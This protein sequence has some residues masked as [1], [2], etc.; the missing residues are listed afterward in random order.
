[1]KRLI[2]ILCISTLFT[3]CELLYS[4][5][6]IEVSP[7]TELSF[8]CNADSVTLIVS[9]NGNWTAGELP[10][11]ISVSPAEGNG[12]DQITVSV[13]ENSTE[14]NREGSF[15]LVCGNASAIVVVTQYGI[16]DSNYADLGLEEPGTSMTYDKNSGTLTVTYTDSTP[17]VVEQGNAVVLGAKYQYDIRVVQS[18]SVSGKTLT[19]R[20]SEGNMCDLFK[21]TSFTLITSGFANT[22]SIGERVIFPS[23]VGYFD[24]HGT[25]HKTHD[26]KGE[27]FQNGQELLAFHTDFNGRTIAQGS[28]GRLYWETCSFDAS[29]NGEFRFDFGEK[30][31]DE[32]RSKGDIKAFS[33]ALMG[34]IDMDFLLHYTYSAGYSEDDDEIIQKNIIRTLSFKFLV[35]NVPV[36][37][38]VDTHLGKCTE[39][40]AE[41]QID[42]T[43]GVKLGTD[44][45]MG[46]EWT[47]ESGARAIPEV[48]PYLELHH[49][50]FEA[51][52]SA[53][54]KVSYY[55]HIDI[56]LYKFLGPWVEPR[57]YLKETVEAGLRASTGGEEYIGYKAETFAGLDM[58][59]G[60]DLDFGI[61]EFN[62]WES[63]MF[64]PVKDQLLFEA[65]SRITLVSP[66]N[67]T[68]VKSGESVTAEFL[69]ESYS[70]L[71][72]IY[73]PCPLALVNLEVDGGILENKFAI[74]DCDGNTHAVWNPSGERS[75]SET[76]IRTMTA[77]VIAADGTLIDD[78]SIMIKVGQPYVNAMIT[79]IEMDGI[80]LAGSSSRIDFTATAR[81][82]TDK[83]IEDHK[84]LIDTSI[85]GSIIYDYYDST[86][87][88]Q[89]IIYD[90][91]LPLSLED[92]SF[93]DD[94]AS[95]K[96]NI[97]LTLHSDS[98]KEIT[99]EPYRFEI[100]ETFELDLSFPEYA[101]YYPAN[102]G[103]IRRAYLDLGY[104]EWV[105]SI[106]IVS[107]GCEP[108]GG[109]SV[110]VLPPDDSHHDC[111][112][113]LLCIYELL[114]TTL[115]YDEFVN[116]YYIEYYS[117]TP[118]SCLKLCRHKFKLKFTF[119]NGDSIYSK[120][121]WLFSG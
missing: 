95:I 84:L 74:S 68:T 6:F 10:Q 53:D 111:D 79:G 32:I 77:K 121:K 109:Y 82:Y 33:Y 93:R 55:P 113:N 63:D 52:A 118:T 56:R 46:V 12:G 64:N 15:T 85:L 81:I 117:P 25:Y 2:I 61:C 114:N 5:D 97:Y 16:L 29:L 83:K 60:L 19:L 72:S 13:T 103:Y 91:E 110:C 17:P 22:K 66:E 20:T 11:W 4:G 36:Y 21:N 94:Y 30:Q 57:P 28:A 102:M 75:A 101:H 107:D 86:S 51:Q 34:S 59:L 104:D 42:A 49:P 70:P 98:F 35:G 67:G 58:K 62:A 88:I 39:F 24:E 92:V 1:M 73:Y 96:R 37:I 116:L 106:E 8:E 76:Q 120:S 80:S 45:N 14:D 90:I 54:A 38:T 108:G 48:S 50:T 43:A 115:Q 100:N 71:T 40:S 99:T 78:T 65:P 69:V 27:F 26:T 119:K 105:S 3:A 9:S 112:P 44:V 87:G 47:K 89:D 18:A 31:I 41:G 7:S 23:E